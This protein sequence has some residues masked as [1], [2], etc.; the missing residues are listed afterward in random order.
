MINEWILR[1]FIGIYKVTHSFI[2]LTS[3]GVE[4]PASVSSGVGPN[5]GLPES[6]R[7]PADSDGWCGESSGRS[8]NK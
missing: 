2:S 8:A 1:N 5:I 4:Y 6:E 3:L 7:R